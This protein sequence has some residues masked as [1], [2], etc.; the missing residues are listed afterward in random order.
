MNLHDVKPFYGS[1]RPDD[2][3][4]L[5]TPVELEM[6]PVDEKNGS[7]SRVHGIIQRC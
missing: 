7:F 6:T 1:Y 4:F 5:L 3:Q 2:V